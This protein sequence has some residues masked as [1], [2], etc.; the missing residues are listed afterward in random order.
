MNL[1]KKIY[2]GCT[3]L[4]PLQF[5][6]RSSPVNSLFPYHHV[7]SDE[8]LAHIINLYPYKNV[9]QFSAD[10]DFLQAFAE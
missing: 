10:L 8:R 4:V 2:Y 5:L 3:D 6:T 1:L 9:K 7:V